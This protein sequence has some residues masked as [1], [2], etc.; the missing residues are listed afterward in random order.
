MARDS[1]N[2]AHTTYVGSGLGVGAA[3]PSVRTLDADDNDVITASDGTSVTVNEDGSVDIGPAVHTPSKRGAGAWDANLAE[4]MESGDLSRMADDYL[5]GVDADNQSRSGFIANYIKGVDMLALK[6]EDSSAARGGDGSISRVRDTLLLESCI[7]YQSGFRGEMLPAAGPAKIAT[8]GGSTG[9]IDQLAK[10]F[11]TDFNYYFTD[12][13]TEFY[14]DSDRGAF[15]QGYGGTL[16][17]KVYRCP[18]RRRPVSESVSV[19]DLIVSEDATDLDNAI[20]VTHQIMTTRA[21]MRR[22][23]LSG[24]WLDVELSSPTGM[25][26]PVKRKVNQAMG[27]SAASQR[28]EDKL[29]TVYEGL[30]DFDPADYGLEEKAPDRLPVPYRLTINRDSRRVLALRRNWDRGDEDFKKRQCYVKYGLIPG[31]GFLDYGFLHLVGQQTRALTG[32]LRILLD[33]GMLNSFPGGLKAKNV[34]MA[35]NQINPALG[36]FVDV[37]IQ[38]MDDIRKA[39]MTMPYKEPSAVLF[40]MSEATRKHAKEV[41]GQV[42][43][44]VGEGRANIPVGTIM[45]MIEAATVVIGAIHKRNHTAQKQ[46]LMKLRELFVEDPT[47]LWKLARKPARRWEVAE[48]FADLDLVPASDPN[49]PSQMHRIMQATVIE[50]LAQTDPQSFDRRA[51]HERTLRVIGV[52]DADSLLAKPGSQPQQQP[53]MPP[54]AAA[55]AGAAAKAQLELPLKQAQLQQKQQELQQ[56]AVEN[57]REAAAQ[58]VEAQQREKDRE[59]EESIET[60]KLGLEQGQLDEQRRQHGVDTAADLVKHVTKPNPAPPNGTKPNGGLQQ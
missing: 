46:E 40:Q 41:A 13:A 1:T 52:N 60:Q 58:A 5:Q 17:K 23:Q 39:L 57:Q 12:I 18:I 9:A 2:R 53:Q 42:T 15:Y 27:L 3:P 29:Y 30:L 49:V 6:I 33:A 8:L 31:L 32:V 55:G 47:A 19:E 54:G 34:R 26:S 4:R 35:T 10:D 37:D 16:Y 56:N 14:P 22:M 36:E 24:A 21:M 59:L 50:T 43:M 48:E 45:S 38:G 44:E 11:E 7:N 20:R 51:V 25:E 28:V